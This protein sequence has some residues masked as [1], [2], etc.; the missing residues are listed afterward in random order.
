VILTDKQ[1][2]LVFLKFPERG[3]VKSRLAKNLDEDIVVSL[4]RYFVYDLLET[5]E[6]SSYCFKICFYPPDAGKKISDWLG[7]QYS[8]M[9]QKGKDLGDRMKNAF[10]EAFSEG[11]SKVLLIGSDIPDLTVAIIHEAFETDNY[12]AVLGPSLD[13]GYY[14]IGFKKNTFLPEIFEGIEWGTEKVFT[15]TMDI[16]R[17]NNY[18]VHI[19]PA[20]QD[21]DTLDDLRSLFERNRD[22]H[23]RNS[24]TMAFLN[25][26]LQKT[27]RKK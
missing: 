20:W 6:K 14:M 2:L 27:L 18:K 9:P 24:Q 17:K 10:Q 1:C 19:L 4:Y 12:D 3:K 15:S 8:Y 23:F 22:T 25:D 7:K 21:I 11:F 13:A 5:L 26:N 16:F